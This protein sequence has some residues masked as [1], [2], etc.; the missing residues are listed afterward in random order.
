MHRT[1]IATSSAMMATLLVI[2]AAIITEQSHAANENDNNTNYG[3]DVSFPIHYNFMGHDGQTDR[4]TSVFGSDRIST[5]YN[6]IVGCIEKYTPTNQG[7]LCRHNE[8]TRLEYNLQQP[9]AVQNHT[10]LGFKKVR[11]SDET[12]SMLQE[13]WTNIRIE[14]ETD[15][16]DVAFP[17]GLSGENW[18][19]GNTYVNYWDRPT[20]MTSI[21]VDAKL[22]SSIW[23]EA[24]DRMREWIPH[25]QLFTRSDIYGIRIYRNGHIL[26]PHVDRDPLVS[27][28]II[29]VDQD[30][31]QEPW[32]L[33]VYDH[34]GKAHNVTVEPG[35]MILYES[36]SVIHGRPFALKGNY[37]AN[38]FVH[39]KP[40]F[41][42]YLPDNEGYYPEE[43][44][45]TGTRPLPS[46]GRSMYTTMLACCKG[47]FGGQSSGKCL[48]E[49]I[50]LD[51]ESE[52]EL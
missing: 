23:Q 37:Y 11:L 48:D 13:F 29:N 36:H 2:L 42:G 5:Y 22:T 31:M 28:A 45:C 16:D 14:H 9:R 4:T 30:G 21:Q 12:W 39:F 6:Y 27:S 1:Q 26:A 24:N 15:N 40:S 17:E 18:P 51:G 3:V 34:Q 47:E 33:E 32:P 46:D 8:N 35:E 25:A 10:E 50:G 38:I 43:D 41:G 20:K 19:T 52:G 44:I 7:H 49:V